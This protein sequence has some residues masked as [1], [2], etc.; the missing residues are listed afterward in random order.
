MC[1]AKKDAEK[2][3]Q[4]VN[5]HMTFRYIVHISTSYLS[6][7]HLPGIFNVAIV[8]TFFQ[9]FFQ[10]FAFTLPTRFP[11]GTD[12]NARSRRWCGRV[13]VAFRSR[14]SRL[15]R[16]VDVWM[17]RSND[18]RLGQETSRLFGDFLDTKKTW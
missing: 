6:V 2:S 1:I 12:S 18:D 3:F 15:C 9:R 14:S 8:L 11:C 5:I 10:R 7:R 13:A 17:P 16:R 4:Y